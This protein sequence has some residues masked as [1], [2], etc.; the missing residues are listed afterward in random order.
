[1]LSKQSNGTVLGDTISFAGEY[2]SVSKSLAGNSLAS[3][4]GAWVSQVDVYNGVLS[5]D[6]DNN[7]SQAGNQETGG[8]G[9]NS[10]LLAYNQENLVVSLDGKSVAS[11]NGTDVNYVHNNELDNFWM[12]LHQ[13][14]VV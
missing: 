4:K 6:W 10:A 2:N 9:V 12:T 14:S 13:A 5:G 8:Q 7:S 11:Y 1:M 3:T